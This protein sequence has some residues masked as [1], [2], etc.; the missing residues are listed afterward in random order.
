MNHK[1][2]LQNEMERRGLKKAEVARQMKI[3]YG[4]FNSWFD[5]KTKPNA[6]D[7]ET[8]EKWL[9]ESRDKEL[10]VTGTPEYAIAILTE[11]VSLL[12]AALN[13]TSLPHERQLIEKDIK[14]LIDQAAS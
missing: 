7:R 9:L 8:I 2:E 10:P 1:E 3:P 12:L 5:Q 11:R 14:A 13:K 6:K 4:R